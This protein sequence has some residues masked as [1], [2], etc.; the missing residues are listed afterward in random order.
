LRFAGRCYR[1]HN[2]LWAHKPLSGDGAAVRGARFNP[3]GV[4]ALYLG[5]TLEAAIAEASQGFGYKIEPLTI[6]MY[7][8]DC[9]DIIDLRDEAG[10][11]A[12][13]LALADMACPWALDLSE[14][15][16][17]ASWRVAKTLIQGGAAGVLVPSFARNARPDAANL[18]L[19]NWSGQPPH[20]VTVHDPNARLPKDQSSW[21]P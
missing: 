15:R 2:P 10:R 4:P 1:A 18:V 5:L 7:E 16:Q 6:C 8:V 12:A 14:G 20:K 13:D 9:E 3:K 19:W 17:P 21:S 11:A